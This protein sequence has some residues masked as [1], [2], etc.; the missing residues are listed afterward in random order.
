LPS[1]R[2]TNSVRPQNDQRKS[3]E[4]VSDIYSYQL[5]RLKH[6]VQQT[7]S[8]ISYLKQVAGQSVLLTCSLVQVPHDR[9]GLLL[10]S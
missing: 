9:F 1:C 7:K 3:N 4:T 8:D 5:D 10:K 2:L 6:S